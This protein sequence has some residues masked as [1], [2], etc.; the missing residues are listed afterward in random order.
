MRSVSLLL[1]A[2]LLTACG[3]GTDT[4]DDTDFA[5]TDVL[6]LDRDGD[7]LSDDF[8]EGRGTDPDD[9]DT[10]ND[11]VFDGAEV[12]LGLDPFDPD[13]D[14]DGLRDG[15][16]QDLGTDPADPDSDD[17]GYADAVEV[18]AGT[19]PNDASDR[20]YTGGWPFYPHKDDLGTSTSTRANEGD[21]VP[22]FQLPDQHGDTFDLYDLAGHGVPTL[23]VLTGDWA[24]WGH[25]V[26]TMLEGEPSEFDA[27][28]DDPGYGWVEGF[29]PVLQRGDLQLVMVLNADDSGGTPDA[30]T[31]QSWLTAHPKLQ[32]PTLLDAEQVVTDWL[33]PG[34]YPVAVLVDDDMRVLAASDNYTEV[35]SAA[36]IRLTP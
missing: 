3:E 16:E 15:D 36:W 33:N 25:Q 14:G 31:L 32:V 30:A 34:G 9:P 20:I 28:V 6:P 17:D 4:P 29:W 26:G 2:T 7:G 5:D 27:N 11:G 23:V 35:F 8:E 21:L 18:A 1:L 13:T 24:Y 22:R 19:D 12:A 10:D